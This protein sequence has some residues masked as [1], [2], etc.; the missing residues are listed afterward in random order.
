MA[1]RLYDL[2]VRG[3]LLGHLGVLHAGDAGLGHLEL[4]LVEGLAFN[5][6]HS[7]AD[8]RPE[9]TSSRCTIL[10]VLADTRAAAVEA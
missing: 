4:S 8:F 1:V 5:L 3:D 7:A 10:C 2:L 6:P 9:E